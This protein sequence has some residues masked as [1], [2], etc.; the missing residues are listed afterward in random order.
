MH[1]GEGDASRFGG[2]DFYGINFIVVK[3][4]AFSAL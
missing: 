2:E 3:T 4:V 1:I